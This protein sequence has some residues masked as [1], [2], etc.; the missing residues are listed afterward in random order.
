MSEPQHILVLANETVAGRSLLDALP[1]PGGPRADPG[2]RHLS[3]ERAAN[4]AR[5]L[6]GEPRVGRRTPASD[7][8][9]TCCTRRGSPRAARSSTPTRCRRS[10]TALYR[11]RPDEVIISTH[12]LARSGWLRKNLVERARKVSNVPVE[13]VVVDLAVTAR[14]RARA[15]DRQ[16]DDRRR[17]AAGR[18]R[19]AS[20]AR[21][22]PTSRWWP[23]RTSPAPSGG[24]VTALARLD[25]AGLD[26]SG[27]LGD[28]DPFTAALNALHDEPIDEIVVS[29]FPKTSSGLASP[30]SDPAAERRDEACPYG[31]W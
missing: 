29:T 22:R 21:A 2:H 9:S 27:H 23:P 18:D 14:A 24:C 30:R 10:A 6:R 25:E 28:P 5:R 16:P 7:G 1:R 13:H 17:R 31:T 26:A 11:Y 12:P 4:R 19:R 3:A 15:R 20:G 8:R